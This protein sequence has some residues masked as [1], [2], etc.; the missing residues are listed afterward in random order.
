MTA[1]PLGKQVHDWTPAKDP[2]G[3]SLRGQY[4]DLS[5]L[6][7]ARDAPGLWHQM[8]PH[9][10]LWDYLSYGP[11]QN[12]DSF[13]AGIVDL[14]QSPTTPCLVVRSKDKDTPLGYACFWTNAPATG[15]TE[16]GNVTLSP[17]LQKTPVATDAFYVMIAWAFE[18]GYRRVEWKCNALNAPSR[19]AAQRLGFS[20]EGIFRNHLVTKGRNRD[21]AWFAIT[22]DDW[23]HI[24]PAYRRWLDPA[25]FDA[26]GV[27]RTSLSALT[28]PLLFQSDPTL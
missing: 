23:T 17:A 6:D 28:R 16:I 10:W 12:L 11:P 7:I 20:Y 3:V 25:N 18:H 15:S 9:P 2:F 22:D 13:V 5:P 27:Q 21:T 4:A 24:A 8:G 1:R 26:K 14:E 19:R